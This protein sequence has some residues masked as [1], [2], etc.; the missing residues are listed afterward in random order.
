M[1]IGSCRA[2]A[3]SPTR[4]ASAAFLDRLYD[5]LA[6]ELGYRGAP[7]TPVVRWRAPYSL[8][9]ISAEPAAGMA[10]RRRAPGPRRSSPAWP[11]WVRCSIVGRA[12]PVGPRRRDDVSGDAERSGTQPGPGP[13]GEPVLIWSVKTDGPIQFNPILVSGV[14]YVGSD[15][16]HLYAL[17]AMSGA[18]RWAFD[19]G[20][21]VKGSALS[22]SG[23]VAVTDA[24][25]VLHVVEAST[26]RERWRAPGIVEVGSVA[27]GI[28]Y[29]P[30]DD[31]RVRG[32]DLRSG[33]D[34]WS[35]QAP[36]RVLYVAVV[37]DVAYVTVEGSVYAVGLPDGV[38]RWHHE[39]AGSE[40]S[41]ATL[42]DDQVYV[43]T[44]QGRGEVTALDRT[45]GARIWQFSDPSGIVISVGAIANGVVYAPS[46]GAGFFALA[47]S[48]GSVLWHTPG[49][50]PLRA[51]PIVDG[52][53]FAAIEEPGGL[54][55]LRA[56]S[57]DALWEVGLGR[58]CRDGRSCPADSPSRRMA[59]AKSRRMAIGRLRSP[60]RADRPSSRPR[61]LTHSLSAAF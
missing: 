34:R 13:T 60:A 6:D 37:D 7:T 59:W 26:G 32:L 4:R 16:G 25:S 2:F 44:R 10:R 23:L 5:D 29:A 35:W 57:G 20:A 58:R 14:L 50:N 12:N 51:T 19:A 61:H 55:A 54:V 46:D 53:I 42:A 30:G 21:P 40:A 56:S 41:V 9:A 15:D 43:S 28:L 45:T 48:D 31:N 11:S 52:M 27:G 17:D 38:E 39:T 22:D 47:A 3:A 18:R 33:A 24:A 49:V 8:A 36:G 1:T